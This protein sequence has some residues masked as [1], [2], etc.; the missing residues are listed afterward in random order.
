MSRILIVDDDPSIVRMLAEV[1]AGEGYEVA[2]VTYS[3]QAFDRATEF[4]PDLILLDLM[5]P[6]LDGFDQLK[7][8]AGD[9]RLKQIPII[10]MTGRA[11]ALDGIEHLRARRVVDFLHKPFEIAALLEKLRNALTAPSG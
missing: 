3:P 5:M 7:I 4:R 2:T 6:D 10:L 9:D 8:L 11:R 1:L